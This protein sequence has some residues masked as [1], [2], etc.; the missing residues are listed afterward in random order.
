M[1]R[2]DFRR[3]RTRGRP[4]VNLKDNSEPLATDAAAQWLAR[5]GG[6]PLPKGKGKHGWKHICKRKKE[7]RKSE[8]APE[9]RWLFAMTVTFAA[10]GTSK[11]VC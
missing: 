2:M 7:R 10:V 3:T 11:R 4:T 6:P 9:R 8:A 1:T 5:H